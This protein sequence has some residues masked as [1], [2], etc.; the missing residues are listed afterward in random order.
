VY[1]AAFGKM[2]AWR[3]KSPLRSHCCG[4]ALI[5]F[6]IKLNTVFSNTASSPSSF[7]LYFIFQDGGQKR[8][9]NIV[10]KDVF[11]EI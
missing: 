3:H 10:G 6:L 11:S 8:G 9:R 7:L 5:S 1:A 2:A 4:I